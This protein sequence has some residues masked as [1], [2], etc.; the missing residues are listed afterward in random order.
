[1]PPTK[2]QERETLLL[3]I[4]GLGEFVRHKITLWWWWWLLLLLL[5]L[6]LWLLTLLWCSPW[7]CGFSRL[8]SS[9]VSPEKKVTLN[10]LMLIWTILELVILRLCDWNIYEECNA[11]N[12]NSAMTLHLIKGYLRWP[13]KLQHNCA[14]T[15]KKTSDETRLPNYVMIR[16]LN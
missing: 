11:Q 9:A 6:L 4:C 12:V 5:L 8:Y 3:L 15:R 16:L 10:I 13:T 1:M 2:S 14:A 7:T